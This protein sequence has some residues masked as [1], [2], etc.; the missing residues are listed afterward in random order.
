MFDRKVRCKIYFHKLVSR[1]SLFFSMM[2]H[3]YSNKKHVNMSYKNV[4]GASNQMTKF[5]GFTMQTLS[6]LQDGVVNTE[7]AYWNN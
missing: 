3:R 6:H 2:N 1:P 5:V 4:I 7:K